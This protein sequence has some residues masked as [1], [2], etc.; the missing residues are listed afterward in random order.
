[1]NAR[2]NEMFK[3]GEPQDHLKLLKHSLLT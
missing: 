2:Q 3:K 1:V